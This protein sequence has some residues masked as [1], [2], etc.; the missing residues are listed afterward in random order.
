MRLKDIIG[1]STVVED[2][3]PPQA[4]KRQARTPLRAFRDLEVVRLS[5]D[6]VSPGGR[7]PSGTQGTV[8]QVFDG[9]RAY[10]IE[11]EGPHDIP[12]T[13][14]REALKADVATSTS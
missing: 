11:F 12:E 7:I 14:P 2:A 13:V 5:Q 4:G 1:C 9:G 3:A 8:L 6:F 10:Q